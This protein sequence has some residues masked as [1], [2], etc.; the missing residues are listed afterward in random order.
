METLARVAVLG[1]GLMGGSLGLALR[2]AGLAASVAGYD[3]APD[4]TERARARGA[5]DVACASPGEA[6][7]GADLVVLATPVLAEKELL[8]A[9]AS[10]LAPTSVVTDLGSTKRQVAE[11]AREL[12]PDPLRFVGGHPMAGSEHSGVEAASADLF[13]NAVW[14]LT[15]TPRTNTTALSLV[16]DLAR[17]LGAA[18]LLLDAAEHDDLV[19]GASHLPLV[20]AAALVRVATGSGEWE[21][22][23]KLAA[24]GFRDS[25]RIASGDTRMARDICLTNRGAL[26]RWLDRYIGEL[27][28]LR[29]VLSASN[30]G[31]ASESDMI[32]RWFAEA[33]QARD[34]WLQR[35]SS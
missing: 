31:S 9:V 30:G 1:L 18:P 35:R 28:G 7:A 23:G 3:V 25:T 24:G 12:L 14:C 20:A 4:T 2:R 10:V 34:D 29:D 21:R 6:V 26:V 22:M 27:S 11:W 16:S 5:I 32:A 15:P 8:A 13:R 17:S 19:A 33:Q